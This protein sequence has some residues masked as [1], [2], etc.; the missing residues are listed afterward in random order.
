MIGNIQATVVK[1]LV[2]LKFLYRIYVTPVTMQLFLF[3]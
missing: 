1:I 2:E 3:T